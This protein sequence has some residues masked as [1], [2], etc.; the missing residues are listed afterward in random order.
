MI[1]DPAIIVHLFDDADL[2]RTEI[3][4]DL[5]AIG[6]DRGAI[7]PPLVPVVGL[8]AEEH[9]DHDDDDIDP[10]REPI[11]RGDM[12]ADTANDHRLPPTL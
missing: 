6:A 8:G 1:P 11:V 12:L 4:D 2:V 3:L 9:A 7:D 10:D 5:R